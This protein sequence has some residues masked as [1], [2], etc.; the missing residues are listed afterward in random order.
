MK[1]PK[2][3]LLTATWFIIGLIVLL[4]NDLYFKYSF[5]GIITGKLSDFAGLFIFPYFLA[6]FFSNHKLKMYGGTAL[7]FI[8]W[9][10]EISQAFIE[11]IA[12]LTH[13][14]TYRTVDLTDLVALSILPVSYWYFKKNEKNAEDNRFV[15]SVCIGTV[16]IIAF[17]ATSQARHTKRLDMAINKE[18]IVPISKTQVF[19]ILKF[20]HGYSD[21]LERNLTDERFYLYFD[22]QCGARATA[23]ATIKSYTKNSTYIRLNEMYEYKIMEP[24][25]ERIDACSK[26]TASD[27]EKEFEL[28]CIDV[29][30][31]KNKND[32]EVYFDNQYIHDNYVSPDLQNFGKDSSG[33]YR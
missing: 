33:N 8:F 30:T 16:S 29:L 22:I 25:Q 6:V 11:Y 7:F 19:K 20:G 31:G 10:H 28:N 5:P 12:Q 1:R 3:N 26:L 13:T 21:T 4:L 32:A 24:N 27:F 17:C 15:L 2:Y 23:F 18:Y 14:H 9:K